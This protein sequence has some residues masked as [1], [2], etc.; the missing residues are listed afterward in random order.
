MFVNK[1]LKIK[2]VRD[3]PIS[4]FVKSNFGKRRSSYRVVDCVEFEYLDA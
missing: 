3:Y 1:V 2:V 4:Y